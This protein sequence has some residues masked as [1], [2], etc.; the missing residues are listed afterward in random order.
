ME[1]KEIKY[2]L[3]KFIADKG[4]TPL[5]VDKFLVDRIENISRTKIQ[6][7]AE[8][9]YLFVNENEVKVNY[10]VKPGD[11]VKLTT[12]Y[13]PDKIE[14]I[15]ENI[16]INIIYEDDTILI[17][18]KEAGMVVHPGYG[19]ESG[20]LVNALMYYLKDLPLFNTGELRPGLVHRLD[21]N[22]SGVM[23]IAKTEEALSD[24]SKQFYDRKPDKVYYALVWGSPKS[25][26]GI[27]QEYI[28]R[29]LQDRKIMRVYPNGEHGKHAITHYKLLK[30]L[31]Y[32]SL[33]ECKLETG[34]T[35]QIRIHL[36][37]IGHPVF[38]DKEYGGNEI[39]RGTRF[40][41]YKQFVNNCFAIMPNQ[42]LHAK[43]LSFI[44][45]VTR[46]IVLFESELPDN[47]TNLLE[48]WE[49]YMIN[50]EQK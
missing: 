28:G 15:P 1:D 7:A 10:K 4:Q 31:G 5:R 18:N 25:S 44:H 46:K 24:I 47:F 19:N 21:K 8:Q 9:G 45:P 48:K 49:Q 17:V 12:F 29:S 23:V 41:K 36:K 42:A 2:E 39:L 32:I 6:K 30:D 3:Y 33:L 50:R 38:G 16:S 11:E 37:Y 26:E 13:K 43:S 27:I 34:R 35:H 14:L 40:T 20:T 22:T